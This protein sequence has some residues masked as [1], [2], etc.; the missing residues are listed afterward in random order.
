MA[1]AIVNFVN[2][3]RCFSRIGTPRHAGSPSNMII[4]DLDIWL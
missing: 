2:N 4:L 1:N 3:V